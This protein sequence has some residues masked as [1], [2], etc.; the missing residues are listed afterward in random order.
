[1]NKNLKIEI[2]PIP[3]FS[4]IREYSDKLE[5]FSQSHK[6]GPLVDPDTYRYKTGL[7][8]EDVKELKSRG[9]PY[10]L[11]DHYVR[12]EP[13]K[14][15]EGQLVKISLINTPIFLYPYKNVLDFIKW[16]Y[17]LVS[18]YVYSSEG[19]MK[20][21]GKSE[22]THYIYNEQEETEIKATKLQERNRVIKEVSA[23]SMKK[24]REII[25]LITDEIVDTKSEDYITV[26]LNEILESSKT[27]KALTV[28][29]T[30]NAKDISL[31][32]DIKK[33]VQNNIITR[34]QK[35]L[36]YFDTPIGFSEEE[37]VLNLSK[38][39]NQ[40]LLISIKDKLKN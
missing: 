1:M 8:E 28:L 23:L 15:W 11:D 24:K 29:L 10:E 22:A 18:N 35:G 38:P 16:K 39:E 9:C 26:K 30:K 32:A 14:F 4:G 5:Y 13:H 12:N 33:A 25:L 34:N 3:N 27:R 19:E 21:G 36:F 6:V 40:E 20:S 37:A 31:E 17:L 7:T 2:R